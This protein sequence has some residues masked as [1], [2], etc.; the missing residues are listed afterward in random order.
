V[1]VDQFVRGHICQLLQLLLGTGDMSE[2]VVMHVSHGRDGL[3]QVFLWVFLICNMYI[4]L[5]KI[6][7]FTCGVFI[8]ILLVIRKSLLVTFF[9][10]VPL[11]F[12][13]DTCI[14]G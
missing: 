6:I 5:K 11:N 1:F 10:A 13:G 2:A 7:T 3:F 8:I 12:G 4:Y 9:T 14:V